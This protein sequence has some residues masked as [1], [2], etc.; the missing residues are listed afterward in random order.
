MARGIETLQLAVAVAVAVGATAALA[1]IATALGHVRQQGELSR[2][3]DSA[4]DLALVP[5]A[6]SRDP[7]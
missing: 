1:V 2:A 7:A 5:A 3:L 6:C 4:R